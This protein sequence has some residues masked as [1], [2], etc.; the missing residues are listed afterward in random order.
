MIANDSS[1]R[2]EEPARPETMSHRQTRTTMRREGTR[3]SRDTVPE[4]AVIRGPNAAA[5]NWN[6]SVLHPSQPYEEFHWK[7]LS[8]DQT[9]F[10]KVST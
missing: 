2:L 5:G 1:G 7:L 3:G 6:R 10:E 8:V 4:K 9:A